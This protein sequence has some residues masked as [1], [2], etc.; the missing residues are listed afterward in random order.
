M[1]A[2]YQLSI[3]SALNRFFKFAFIQCVYVCV[4]ARP[5]TCSLSLTHIHVPVL[6]C[7]DQ[8][9]VFPSQL[10]SSLG[11]PGIELRSSGL[12]ASAVTL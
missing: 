10:L 1:H 5:C 6:I 9:T 8:R 4:C 12:A 7:E 3:A 2:L 11:L